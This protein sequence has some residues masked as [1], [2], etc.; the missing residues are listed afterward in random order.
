MNTFRTIYGRQ[1]DRLKKWLKRQAGR[2]VPCRQFAGVALCVLSVVVLPGLFAIPQAAHA[3]ERVRIINSDLLEG[4][5]TAQGRLRKLTGNVELLT[6]DFH[7]VCDSA[8]HY[9][10]MDELMAFGNIRITTDREQIWSDRATYDLD[11]EVSHFEGRVV[12]QSENALL[13]SQEVFYSFATEIALFP[14][15]LRLEDNRGVM[16]ADSGY[17]Y[18]ALDSA[19]VRGRV[20]LSDSLQYIEADSMFSSR[21]NDYHELHGQVFLDD[22]ENR[23]RLSG[24]FLLSDSTGYRRVEGGAVMRQINEEQTDT[25]WLWSDWLEVRRHIESSD[26]VFTFTAYNQVHTWAENYSTLADTTH[27]DDAPGTLKLSGN[28]QLWYENTQLTGPHIL[29]HIEQDSIRSLRAW[30]Q[31]FAVQ[32]DTTL[33]RMNQ[34]TGDTL[35][36]SF[37]R[38]ELAYILAQPRSRI[39][40]F[41]KSSEGDPDGAI[42]LGAGSIRLDFEEGELLDVTALESPEGSY[43]PENEE[44]ADERLEGF[45]WTPENRP[46]RPGFTIE[47]RFPPIPEER[48][49]ELPPGFELMRPENTDPQR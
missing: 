31:P 39:F 14:G 25:T 26:T 47:P 49:F 45:I 36:L 41:L 3:Q 4:E 19:V 17:Y 11:A 5:L 40:Y 32:H 27:Y 22:L 42:Q 8:W 30:P 6:D 37:D 38:G 35:F 33:D 29:I 12:M 43:L 9:I 1:A 44:L 28:P 7:I 2:P 34:I 13:F 15:Q 48:P 46:H 18:N 20:Q 21:R 16:L 23:T 24:Q 10:D